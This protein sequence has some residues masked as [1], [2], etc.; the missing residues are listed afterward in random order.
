MHK[1][2]PTAVAAR[3][4]ERPP[5][6]RRPPRLRG[7]RHAPLSLI[8]PLLF[9]ALLVTVCVAVSVGSVSVRLETV[10]RVIADHLTGAGTSASVMDDQIVWNLRLPRVLLAAVVGAGLALVGVTLQATVR[11]PLADPYVLGVSAGAGLMAS[12]VITLGSVAVAGLSTSA[13]AF[14]GALMAMVAV[15]GLSRRAGRVVPGRLILAGVTL[16][17][18]FSG[19]TSFVIFRSGNAEAAHSVL[20]WLLGSLSESS[21]SNLALPAAAVLVVGVHL[22]VQTRTLNALA[23]GDDAALSLGVS[24]HRVRIRLLVVASLLTGV[25]VAVSGGIGFVGLIVPHLVRLVVG[26]DHRRLLPI[27]MLVGAIY[28]VVVDVLCRVLVRPEELPIGIITA[29]LGAPVFLWLLRRSEA[30]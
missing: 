4:Q 10:T 19:A 1:Q 25:L 23:A 17:Y 7:G 30:S 3:A 8:A 5:G 22:M 2:T 21:W 11:N 12:I 20:F 16:S 18:L 28:L 27:A 15:L 9:A 26:P 29:V 24:V 13:A 14:V 6:G